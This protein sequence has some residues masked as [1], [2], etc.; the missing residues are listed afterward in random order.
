MSCGT[1]AIDNCTVKI[2]LRDDRLAAACLSMRRFCSK[3]EFSALP[4]MSTLADVPVM[5]TVS[6]TSCVSSGNAVTT[7]PELASHGEGPARRAFM[8]RVGVEARDGKYR[9][10]GTSKVNV[11]S[12]KYRAC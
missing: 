10:S 5:G 4:V 11:G 9:T 8:I 12:K 3:V 1:P 6:A 7:A 2:E